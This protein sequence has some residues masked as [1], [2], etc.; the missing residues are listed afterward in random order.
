MDNVTDF[1]NLSQYLSLLSLDEYDLSC[2]D[3]RKKKLSTANCVQWFLAAY[4]ME[5][6]SSR[7]METVLRAEPSLQKILGIESFSHSQVT[8]RLPQIPTELLQDLFH[9]LIVKC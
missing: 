6:D 2:F 8:R 7:D 4:L 5:L 1:T 3:Y 9:R